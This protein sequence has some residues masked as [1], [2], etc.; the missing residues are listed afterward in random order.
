MPLEKGYSQ[1][2][3][4][5][6]IREMIK[7]GHPRE[8]AIAASLSSARNSAKKPSYKKIKDKLRKN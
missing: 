4:S 8:Q 1:K 7:S 5:H 2:T 3:I 6:N